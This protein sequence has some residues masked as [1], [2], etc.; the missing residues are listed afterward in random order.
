[1]ALSPQNASTAINNGRG[2]YLYGI[3]STY[4]ATDLIDTTVKWRFD[5]ASGISVTAPRPENVANAQEVIAATL[6]DGTIIEWDK[7]TVK[8]DGM[9]GAAKS[10]TTTS[11]ALGTIACEVMGA[12]FTAYTGSSPNDI[13]SY[14]SLMTYYEKFNSILGQEFLIVVPVGYTATGWND[15][16]ST[17]KPIAFAALIGVLGADFVINNGNYTP[18]PQGIT[19]TGRKL[20]AGD[21]DDAADKLATLA[22][23]KMKILEGDTADTAF[24]EYTPDTIGAT[25]AA[26]LVNG[27]V[28]ILDNA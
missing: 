24:Y 8:M 22:L 26:K 16:R 18:T 2:V 21:L 3:D 27:Y 15:R 4:A 17:G 23:P 9:T 12:P 5:K 1:M 11:Q 10:G 13:P 7:T 28:A 19:I 25:A 20:K 14:I 6:G